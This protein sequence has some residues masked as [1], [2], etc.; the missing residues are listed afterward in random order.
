MSVS[1]VS[2]DNVSGLATLSL[3]DSHGFGVGQ[4]IKF[5][6]NESVY[7]GDFIVTEILMIWEFPHIR[8]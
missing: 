2:Y 6:A 5:S 8:L 3:D 7:N 1:S 4:K